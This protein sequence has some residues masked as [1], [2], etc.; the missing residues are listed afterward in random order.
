LRQLA[1]EAGLQAARERD[2]FHAHALDDRQMVRI[3][4][5]SPELK[6]PA[7]CRECGSSDV[8]SEASPGCTKNDGV[9]VLARWRRS[10]R[11]CA[12]FCHAD[13]DDPSGAGENQAAGLGEL[14]IDALR[15]VCNASASSW[16][17]S[18]PSCSYDADDDFM[19]FAI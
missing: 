19:R 11:R 1:R 16:I 14:S 6:S 12:R 7:R 18:R 17:T 9:P 13:D 3:S 10:C 2:E 4:S 8:A 5:V 15:R